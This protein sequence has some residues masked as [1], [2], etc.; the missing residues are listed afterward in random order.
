MKEK[1]VTLA[2]QTEERAKLMIE[3][4]KKKGIKG[5]IEQ[6]EQ[7]VEAPV[8]YYKVRT[9]VKD[10][11]KALETAKEIDTLYGAE[12]IKIPSENNQIK[13]ILIPIVFKDYSMNA[14]HYTLEMAAKLNAN[15][16]LFHAYFNPFTNPEAYTEDMKS[17]GYFDNHVYS[18]EEEAQE[19]LKEMVSNMRETLQ[20]KGIGGIEV[21][22]TLEG[23]SIYAGLVKTIHTYHPDLIV[24]G[25]KGS[26]KK[27]HDLMGRFTVKAVGNLDVPVLTIPEDTQFD[28]QD[29]MNIL[30][31]T[32]FDSSDFVSLHQ[33]LNMWEGLNPKVY[34][35][36]LD[37]HAD[38]DRMNKNMDKLEG[39]FNKYYPDYDVVCS[40][41]KGK[42]VLTDLQDFIKE[43]NINMLSVTRHKHNI[44]LKYF[45]SEPVN[46][47]VFHTHIPLLVYPA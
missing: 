2:A 41:V 1:L 40:V 25:T 36:H 38:T 32:D 28:I 47:I 30:H 7:T 8:Q 3:N 37:K 22:A 6:V 20:K 43:K 27:Y 14:C 33:L 16:Q 45:V 17:G 29:R 5:V 10:L 18:I 21:D 4:L 31:V 23:G 46:R 19:R 9:K 11:S 44:L 42:D 12:E 15:I 13:D 34:C 35:V 26:G 39:F 24:L